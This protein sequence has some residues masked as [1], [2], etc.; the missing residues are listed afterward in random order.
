ML[1]PIDIGADDDEEHAALI[2]RPGSQMNPVD[3]QVH[4]LLVPQAPALPGNKLRAKFRVHS[5]DR[6][7]RE[8]RVAAE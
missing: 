6:R 3:P 2:L 7:G 5:R 4:E 1:D 8:R